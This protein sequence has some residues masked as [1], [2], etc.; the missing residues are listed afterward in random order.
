[1][2]TIDKYQKILQDHKDRKNSHKKQG[3]L[4][5]KKLLLH[6][7]DSLDLRY[8]VG[9]FLRILYEAMPDGE[10]GQ[11]LLRWSM[12]QFWVAEIKKHIPIFN[13]IFNKLK[14]LGASHKN[15]LVYGDIDYSAWMEEY[16][17]KKIIA[18]TCHPSVAND[19]TLIF[20][21]RDYEPR[22]STFHA[23]TVW[24]RE[25]AWKYGKE[26]WP[27]D[28]CWRDISKPS[29]LTYRRHGFEPEYGN[30]RDKGYCFSYG[31]LLHSVE[32]GENYKIFHALREL[33]YIKEG[34]RDPLELP[35]I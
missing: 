17:E 5:A 9:E 18:L 10:C 1:M 29:Y 3:V 23:R 27:N 28:S 31:R 24:P 12:E 32:H 25:I 16:E 14:E 35:K 6:S 11:Q 34:I 4:L 33:V 30:E 7:K 2:I 13:E 20:I 21:L 19:N 8:S 26:N 22:G 15:P